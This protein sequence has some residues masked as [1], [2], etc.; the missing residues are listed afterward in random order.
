[1]N[2]NLIEIVTEINREMTLLDLDN[3]QPIN[4]LPV[5]ADEMRS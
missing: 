3:S 2:N 5:P 4:R 1:M